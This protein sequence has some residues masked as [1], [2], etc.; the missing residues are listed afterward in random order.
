MN[1]GKDSRVRPGKDGGIELSEDV[2][3]LIA[4]ELADVIRQR[5]AQFTPVTDGY[6]AVIFSYTLRAF[7]ALAELAGA[8]G[9]ADKITGLREKVL[10]EKGRAQDAGFWMDYSVW[11]AERRVNGEQAPG[12]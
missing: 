11:E 1:G 4:G 12:A 9:E 8:L 5:V 3:R 7:C 6:R 2:A 10:S